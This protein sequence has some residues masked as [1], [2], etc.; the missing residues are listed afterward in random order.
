VA[1]RALMLLLPTFIQTGDAFAG[2]QAQAPPAAAAAATPWTPRRTPW[3]DPDLQGLWTNTT[4]TPLERPDRFAGKETLTQEE[5]IEL[6]RR[7]ARDADRPQPPTT[8][9]RPTSV[10]FAPPGNVGAYNSWWLEKGVASNQTSLIVDPPDGKLPPLTLEAQHRNAKLAAVRGRPPAS[11]EDTNLMERCITRGMPGLMMPGFY[12]HNYHLLQAPGYV[13][14]LLEMFHDARIIPVDGRPH[15]GQDIRLWNGDS[16][17]RWEGN[18]LVVETTNF[19]DRIHER[20]PTLVVFGTGKSLHL[21]ERFTRVGPDLID[22]RFTVTDP[23]TFTRPWTASTPM[24][25]TEGPIL[26]YA[27]HEGN[28]AMTNILRGA[29]EQEKREQE[30]QRKTAGEATRK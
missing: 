24:S 22:Y 28:Y 8:V 13:V 16:R 3:G 12:N 14:I 10:T 7:A 23:T 18:T 21:V 26:E 29:R 15:V 5:R 2:D 25:R 27:C 4:T 17:G 6:D 30:E 9:E 20:R 1:A 19:N 11:W